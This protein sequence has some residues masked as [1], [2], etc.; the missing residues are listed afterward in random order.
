MKKMLIIE[1]DYLSQKV[2]KLIF[3]NDYEMDYCESAKEYYEKFANTEY[4]IIIMDISI[5]G[6]KNG[7]ELIKEIKAAPGYSGTPI[8]CLTAHAQSYMLQTAIESGSDLCI[9]KPVNNNIL[10]DAVRSLIKD[11]VKQQVQIVNYQ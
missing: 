6:D 1:D 4:G 5:K 7:L 9:T 10:K 3:Q 8:L 11:S 2:M